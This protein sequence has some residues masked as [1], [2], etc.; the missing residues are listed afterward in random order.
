MP[1]AAT[2][3][4]CDHHK[5]CSACTESLSREKF[6]KK[7]WEHKKQRRCK[8]CVDSNREIGSASS[9]TC[10]SK[11]IS[12]TNTNSCSSNR[13][14]QGRNSK[15]KDK[16]IYAG[17]S[18]ESYYK[19]SKPGAFMDVKLASYICSW[20]GKA[21]ENEKLTKCAE[22]KNVFYCS[23][24]CQKADW[25]DHKLLCEKMK[26]DRKDYKKEKKA[27]KSKG[28]KVIEKTLNITEASG[29]G[30]F[31]LFYNHEVLSVHGS[32]GELRGY[33]EPGQ[34]FASDTVKENLKK[35]LGPGFKQ[36]YQ[37]MEQEKM[38]D[39]GTL[40]RSEVF[41]T[42]D[43]LS[44][45]DQFLLSCGPFNELERAKSVLPTI[46]S[47]IRI[48]G[49]KPD[50]SIP[51]IGDITARGYG[52]NALEWAARRGNYD[53]AKW[54]ATDARTKVML[55]RRDSAP[56]AWACYTNKVELARMLVE[57]G[58]DSHSTYDSVFC[59]KP[60]S[61]LASE[62][63][64]LHALKYLVEECSHD[65]H[66]CD[67]LGQDIRASIR[68]N[69]KAWTLVAGCVACDDYA[70]SMG[71][72]GDNMV[73]VGKQRAQKLSNLTRALRALEI[74]GGKEDE[75]NSDSDDE[76]NSDNPSEY[77]RELLAVGDAR[78]ELG[79]YEKASSIYYRS[80]YAA[81]HSESSINNPKI[82]PIAHKMI[83]ANIKM[84]TESSLRF[85]HGF[86]QQNVNM[87]GPPS[88]RKDLED[89]E[90]IIKRKGF[91]MGMMGMGGFY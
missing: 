11:L 47:Q 89:V 34:Y 5:H 15:T 24:A 41:Q 6:S 68:C 7:Q 49:L 17:A 45:I 65:I 16:P 46:L 76:D 64:Q 57:H 27:H 82:F 79:Q 67:T 48:S 55:T 38:K 56:V 31:F 14:K 28:G 8:D 3:E 50:G 60:P 81:M 69:N 26:K 13:K 85:A 9:E 43:D 59:S 83:Q 74:A 1:T 12:N 58:A 39:R 91:G 37:K 20:C 40:R 70:K 62:N 10:S 30:S 32:N 87:R 53:I 88:T 77:W 86:A 29:T 19:P 36:L 23:P 84:D 33:E 52:L 78:Y 51:N 66:E 44:P 22:C 90:R 80:Y 75:A 2:E 42:L 61:H 54:L 18:R 73:R 25:P 4:K 71:V 72:T 63:G 35:T 21:E